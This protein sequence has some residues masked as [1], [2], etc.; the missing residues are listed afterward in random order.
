M[1]DAQG[2]DA[3]HATPEDDQPNNTMTNRTPEPNDYATTYMRSPFGTL[4]IEASDLGVS[5]IHWPT[6]EADRTT[7]DAASPEQSRSTGQRQQHLRDAVRQ[8]DEYFAGGRTEF[9]LPVDLHG[10][11]FQKAVWTALRPIPF[12]QTVSYGDLAAELGRPTASRA[13]G[14][15]VGAN[16]VPIVLPCHR[17]IGSTGALTGFA[18]GI[19]FK[20]LLLRHEGREVEGDRVTPMTPAPPIL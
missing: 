10:T 3:H 18:P 12:G 19:P 9:D 7:E 8:L 1:M 2:S 17:V 13:V 5:A 4:T 16:P 6:R 15:A 14:R 20:V 11:A